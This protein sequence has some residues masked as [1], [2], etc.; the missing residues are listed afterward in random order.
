MASNKGFIMAESS[1][2]E[3]ARDTAYRFL[4]YRARSVMEVEKK[5]KEKGFDNKTISLTLER[6]KDLKLLDDAD[7][8]ERFTRELAEVRGYGRY[9]IEKKLKEK[10]IAC[11]TIQHLI[12]AFTSQENEVERA[13]ILALKKIKKPLSDRKEKERIGRYLQGKGYSWEIIIETIKVLD[14]WER[15]KK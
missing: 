3:K 11:E 13:K 10:G 8:A 15:D 14:D 9:C 4:S 5:L 12:Q 2:L 1:D 6:L 7:F